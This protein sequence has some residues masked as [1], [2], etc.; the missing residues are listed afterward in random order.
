MAARFGK[1]MTSRT[2]WRGIASIVFFLVLWEI[3]SR[4]RLWM[5]P[6]MY[7]PIKESLGALGFK[8]DYLP[9]IGALPTPSDVLKVWMEVLGSIG[10]WQSWYMSFFR[11]MGGLFAAMLIGIPF[12]LL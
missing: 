1:W 8:K 9:W 7:S 3:G 5:A 2:L 12:G 11:V 10:Y 4:S 6:E